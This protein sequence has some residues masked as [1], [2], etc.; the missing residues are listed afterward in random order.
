VVTTKSNCSSQTTLHSHTHTHT[1]HTHTQVYYLPISSA[2]GCSF[3]RRT[4]NGSFNTEEVC[5]SRYMSRQS[6]AQ[7]GNVINERHLQFEEHFTQT[8]SRPT[9]RP[10][11]RPTDR[12]TDRPTD[13]PTNQ[14]TNQ[15]TNQPTN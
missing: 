6:G 13:R 9:D 10:N 12:T 11:D 1:P 5:N 15:P 7:S 14:L 8:R 4:E 2:T 3:Y